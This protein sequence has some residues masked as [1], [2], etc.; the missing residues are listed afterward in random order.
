ML[1]DILQQLISGLCPGLYLQNLGRYLAMAGSVKFVSL[2]NL[3]IDE[4]DSC[5]SDR[6]YWY[7]V[8]EDMPG[9]SIFRNEYGVREI[10]KPECNECSCSVA[11]RAD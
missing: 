8:A 1:Q 2:L 10:I 9:T 5:H 3:L 11:T 4:L 6:S 7:D